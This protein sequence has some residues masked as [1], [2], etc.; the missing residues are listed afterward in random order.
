MATL[1]YKPGPLVRSSWCRDI[2]SALGSSF[3]RWGSHWKSCPVTWVCMLQ[4]RSQRLRRPRVHTRRWAR[5][6]GSELDSGGS[7]TDS[8]AMLTFRSYED[9][10]AQ[11]GTL[12]AEEWAAVRS[13]DS[14]GF[15][16]QWLLLWM[17]RHRLREAQS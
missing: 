17:R 6:P 7:S 16:V 9:A 13:S 4:S 5:C 14:S 2:M 10:M 1:C 12:V 8:L 3:G 15:M 11:A